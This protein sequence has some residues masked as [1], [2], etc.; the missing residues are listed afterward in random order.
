MYISKKGLFSIG[1][2]LVTM[3][4][5][6]ICN[7]DKIPAYVEFLTEFGDLPLMISVTDSLVPFTTADAQLVR[8]TE[9][10]KGNRN[11]CKILSFKCMFIGT[12]IELE[13]SG[14]GICDR[15]IGRCKCFTGFGSSNGTIFAAGER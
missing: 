15:K 13:C 3:D 10:Q 9:A 11:F 4:S 8:I 12:F 2:V 5:T 6:S 14:Q 1:S 7:T